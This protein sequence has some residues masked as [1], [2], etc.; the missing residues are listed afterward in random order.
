MATMTRSG[1]LLP[2]RQL[3]LNIVCPAAVEE[4]CPLA[5][6]TLVRL[7]FARGQVVRWQG[8]TGLTHIVNAEA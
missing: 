1:W 3:D 5:L 8:Q 4:E 2:T 7:Q 6:S